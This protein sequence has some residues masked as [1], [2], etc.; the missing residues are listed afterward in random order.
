VKDEQKPATKKDLV[1]LSEAIL[2][3]V[4]EMISNS[5]V[6]LKKE[7]KENRSELKAEIQENRRQINSL[8]LDTPTRKEFNDLKNKVDRHLPSN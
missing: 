7:I 2:N 4:G 3:G 8:K 1:E 5:E 6:K